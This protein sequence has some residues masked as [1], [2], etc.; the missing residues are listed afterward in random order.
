MVEGANLVDDRFQKPEER[1][2]ALQQ[3][4][5]TAPPPKP[6]TTTQQCGR[7]PA[8]AGCSSR[9]PGAPRARQ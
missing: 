2:H 5:D 9:H 1:L 6:P 8:A 4:M 7:A 3:W